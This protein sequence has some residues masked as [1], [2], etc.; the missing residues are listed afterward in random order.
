MA[1]A[2]A[3]VNFVFFSSVKRIFCIPREG[4][5]NY[6]LVDQRLT[7]YLNR[8]TSTMLTFQTCNSGFFETILQMSETFVPLAKPLAIDSKEISRS[9]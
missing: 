7:T 1:V 6:K 8:I 5:Y 4:S 2:V 3:G 9:S